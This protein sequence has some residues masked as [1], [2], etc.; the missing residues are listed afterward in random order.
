MGIF[1]RI[2]ISKNDKGQ[3]EMRTDGMP[4]MSKAFA[5]GAEMKTEGFATLKDK[6]HQDAEKYHAALEELESAEA[7]GEAVDA[8]LMEEARE[9]AMA[10]G[11]LMAAFA[12][13]GKDASDSVKMAI[14]SAEDLLAKAHGDFAKA[15]TRELIDALKRL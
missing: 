3:F 6:A 7:Q 11:N 8:R 1:D 12:F 9:K 5:R 2:F 13:E 10:Y 14:A 15:K 4:Q